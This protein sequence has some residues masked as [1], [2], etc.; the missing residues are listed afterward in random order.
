[1]SLTKNSALVSFVTIG[2]LFLVGQTIISRTF[3]A[4][5]VYLF[6][7]FLYYVLTN[8]IGSATQAIEK[9]MAVYV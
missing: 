1:M 2:E 8:L 6:I 5:T 9:K 3:D 4:L 7:G